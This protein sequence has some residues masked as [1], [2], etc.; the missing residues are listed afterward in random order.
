MPVGC[1]PPRRPHSAARRRGPRLRRSDICRPAARARRPLCSPPTD[2]CLRRPRS[3]STPASTLPSASCSLY[4]H[5]SP[6]SGPPLS[7]ISPLFIVL[8][9]MSFPHPIPLLLR[10]PIDLPSIPPPS[11]RMITRLAHPRPPRGNQAFSSPR[12]SSWT[13]TKPSSILLQSPCL[14][15]APVCSA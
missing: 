14:P 13:W 6:I 2:P 1:P 3:A 4:A 9:L 8:Q 7:R 12:P 5:V 11:H 15:A 10:H